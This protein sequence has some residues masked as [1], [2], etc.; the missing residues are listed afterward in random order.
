MWELSTFIVY[1]CNSV[2][3]LGPDTDASLYDHRI[4]NEGN[5]CEGDI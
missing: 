3:S 4:D 2:I 5:W 1:E